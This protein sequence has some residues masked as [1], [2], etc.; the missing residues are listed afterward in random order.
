MRWAEFRLRVIPVFDPSFPGPIEGP[1]AIAE[2]NPFEIICSAVAKDLLNQPRRCH[3][4][5]HFADM[6]LDES[7]NLAIEWHP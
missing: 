7:L 6:L 1:N 5:P 4:R 2:I 3:I